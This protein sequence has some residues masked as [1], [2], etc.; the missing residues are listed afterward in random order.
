M[1]RYTFILIVLLTSVKAKAQTDSIPRTIEDST[2]LT[3]ARV[4]CRLIM[5]SI[6][7]SEEQA[8]SLLVIEVSYYKN[9]SKLQKEIEDL[10]L[11]RQSLDELL[12]ARNS[13]VNNVLNAE[14]IER[15]SILLENRKRKFESKK[16]PQEQ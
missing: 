11:L 8:D 4:E 3:L 7:L 15:Y 14:Q 9:V 6:T 16:I 5:D 13:A 12:N 1:I 2:A 10:D